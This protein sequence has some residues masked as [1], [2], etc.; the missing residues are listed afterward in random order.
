MIISD[1]HYSNF[2]K[3]ISIWKL[4]DEQQ[5]VSKWFS[6]CFQYVPTLLFINKFFAFNIF[7]QALNVVV[8]CKSF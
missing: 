1:N 5:Q 4:F 3:F 8:G 6:E 7:H 2:P